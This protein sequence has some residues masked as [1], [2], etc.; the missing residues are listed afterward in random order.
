MVEYMT[1][2][3]DV[4]ALFEDGKRPIFRLILSDSIPLG[5]ISRAS[6][7]GR[8]P[9][10]HDD[11]SPPA[12]ESTKEQTELPLH[13]RSLHALFLALLYAPLTQSIY[14]K[15]ERLYRATR[16]IKAIASVLSLPLTSAICASA[17]VIFMQPTYWRTYLMQWSRYGSSFLLFALLV[18]LLGLIIAPIQ[19]IFLGS[20][21]V[22]MPTEIQD[23]KILWDLS[24]QLLEVA[25]YSGRD[26]NLVT[27]MTRAA[28]ANA[29]TDE[30]H[31]Q[32]WPGANVTCDLFSNK[33]Y[34]NNVCSRQGAT[35][36]NI[37]G[38]PDPFVAQLTSNFHTGLLQ[39][40]LPR[41]NSTTQ[42]QPIDEADF[43]DN[44]DQI[45]DAFFACMPANLTESPWKATRDRHDFSEEL[46]ID[47]T[48]DGYPIGEFDRALYKIT[49]STTTGYFELPNYMNA[50]APGF[51]LDK[52]PAELCDDRCENQDS[53]AWR[54]RDSEKRDTDITPVPGDLQVVKNKA[55]PPETRAKYPEIYG[56]L[57]TWNYSI[58]DGPRHYGAC[59][60]LPLGQ[61][62]N[63]FN[64]AAFIATE[65]WLDHPVT[66]SYSGIHVLA[67]LLLGLYSAWSPRWTQRLDSF[68]M[69]RIG[70]AISQHVSLLMAY[71]LNM[72]KGLRAGE[73]VGLLGLGG[74]L[75]LRLGKKYVSYH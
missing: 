28:L 66:N 71:R 43:S 73:G 7:Q 10:I 6:D 14:K 25:K 53:Y 1:L 20:Q 55:P 42:F 62:D 34:S 57:A 44:C 39:Q 41:I 60:D 17:A 63:A 75:R 16:I 48:L 3:R 64:A 69:M 40:F 24:T 11:D 27:I 50:G 33:R 15:T 21:A 13:H 56:I 19:S 61:L 49:L 36:E 47:V 2:L 59:R 70:G 74:P 38:Y 67:L 5:P 51:L 46:Y 26:S 22:K 35:F 52:D 30:T 23:I 32:L 72:V 4:N 58:S 29:T 54:K 31:A 68:A 8:L 37:S 65:K 12:Y 45:L 9:S 18:S